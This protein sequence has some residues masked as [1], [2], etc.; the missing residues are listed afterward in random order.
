MADQAG[1][2][3][4]GH[5]DHVTRTYDNTTSGVATADA[6]KWVVP[7]GNDNVDLADSSGAGGSLVGVMSDDA[8]NGDLETVHVRG[9]LWARVDGAV[10]AGDELAPP[11]SGGTG[12]TTPG[13]AANGGS[14]GIFALGDARADDVTG[15]QIAPVLIR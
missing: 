9:V 6:G 7:T 14:S 10:S 11:D 13:V 8:D 3:E 2:R 15:N 4:Y 12:V 1:D 5:G